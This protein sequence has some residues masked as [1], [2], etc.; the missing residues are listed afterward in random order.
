MDRPCYV[1][2]GTH[3]TGTTSLQSLLALNALEL[4]FAGLYVPRAGRISPMHAGH[5]SI[6]WELLGTPRSEAYRGMLHALTSELHWRGEAAACISSEEFEFLAPLPDAL[7]RLRSGI[8]ASGFEPHFVVYLRSQAEYSRSLVAELRKNDPE[9][10]LEAFCDG[11]LEQGEFAGSVLDYHRLLAGFADVVGDDRIIV[12]R[13]REHTLDE[14]DL[15]RD[16]L[17]VVAPRA[18]ETRLTWPE[19]LNAAPPILAPPPLAAATIA[20]FQARF[21]PG[22]TRV[23]ERFGVSVPVACDG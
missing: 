13:Y 15:L 4:S 5:H 6:A 10:T 20:R 18:D 16:F 21:G 12:R 11:V 3:K 22:N 9:L 2:I 7:E 1:H 19:R 14:R 8:R 23:A 17:G